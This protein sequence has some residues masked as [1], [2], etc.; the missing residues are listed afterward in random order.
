MTVDP[1][2]DMHGFIAFVRTGIRVVAA[3]FVVGVATLI[4]IGINE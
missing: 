1:P 3:L 4:V 2:P